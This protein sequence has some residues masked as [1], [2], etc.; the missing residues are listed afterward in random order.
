MQSIFWIWI[1]RLAS[2]FRSYGYFRQ[3]VLRKFTIQ[4]SADSTCLVCGLKGDIED[5]DANVLYDGPLSADDN[6]NGIGCVMQ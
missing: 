1:K 2:A 3:R 5:K 4:L 6:I